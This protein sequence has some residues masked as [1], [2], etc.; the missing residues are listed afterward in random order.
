MVHPPLE[1]R[2]G[3]G[4]SIGE[5]RPTQCDAGHPLDVELVGWHPCS[6]GGHRTLWCRC[7]LDNHYRA[8]EVP[9]GKCAE[10]RQGF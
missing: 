7:G 3:E 6:C 1:M 8:R 4:S 5:V 2:R 9:I 10:V